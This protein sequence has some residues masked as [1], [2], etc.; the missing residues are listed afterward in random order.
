M[1]DYALQLEKWE[2]S[3]EMYRELVHFCRQ[4][5]DKKSRASFERG[6]QA[7]VSNGMPS[8][9]NVSDPTAARAI[10]AL[11][12]QKDVDDIDTAAHEAAQELDGYLLRHVTRGVPYSCLGVPCG[13][14]Q[15]GQMRRKFYFLLAQKRGMI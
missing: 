10:R 1:R 3:R 6:M 5:D 7:I 11:K 9:G 15:F 4:Y 2:I 8:A 12:W 13:I 14:N